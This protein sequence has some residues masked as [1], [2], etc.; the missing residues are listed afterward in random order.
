[1]ACTRNLM[2]S[3]LFA[4]PFV[5]YQPA[6]IV[7]GQPAID[8][9]NLTKQTMLGPP[10]TWPWN[11]SEFSVGLVDEI[12]GI[13]IEPQQD[14]T[15]TS[16]EIPQFGFLERVWLRAI[17]DPGLKVME[18]KVVLSLAEEDAQMRPQSVA[19]QTID[20]DDNVLLRFNSR[21]DQAYVGKGCY[22]CAAS[23]ITSMAS[24]WK[25]IPDHLS[26]IYDWGYMSFLAL[27]VRDPRASLYSQ[28]FAAHLL[29]AQDGLTA[30]QRNIFLA[31]F[32]T[33]MGEQQRVPQQQ[34]QGVSARQV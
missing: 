8:A 26:Y 28:R 9:A 14:Y 2:A 30:T 6:D 22:Q 25:P 32:L 16:D 29:G 5:G 31:N 33:L 34:A 17:N 23:V 11:R 15:L 27:L 24:L 3:T 4:L 1:M 10:F 20:E 19:A 13:T 21:P 7:N 18:L 12:G